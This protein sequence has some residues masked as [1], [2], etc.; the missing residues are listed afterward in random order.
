MPIRNRDQ[1]IFEATRVSTESQT[2]TRGQIFGYI[3]GDL[4]VL[5][6]PPKKTI[7]VMALFIIGCFALGLNVDSRNKTLG[8]SISGFS[9]FKY[10]NLG[11]L[12]LVMCT[13]VLTIGIIVRV[14]I[15]H[16]TRGVEVIFAQFKRIE[17][18][19]LWSDLTSVNVGRFLFRLQTK[20]IDIII[21]ERILLKLEAVLPSIHT[22]FLVVG[23]VW[24][25]I[26]ICS[27]LAIAVLSPSLSMFRPELLSCLSTNLY[28]NLAIHTVPFLGILF[29]KCTLPYRI[30][31]GGIFSNKTLLIC[32]GIYGAVPIILGLVFF[33]ETGELVYPFLSL[34]TL[35][36]T[37]LGALCVGFIWGAMK[38]IQRILRAYRFAPTSIWSHYQPFMREGFK[39]TWVEI[40]KEH[41][42]TTIL[43]RFLLLPLF[44]V[45]LGL[46]IFYFGNSLITVQK[47]QIYVRSICTE[48]DIYFGKIS[49]SAMGMSR[50]LS[51]ASAQNPLATQAA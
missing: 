5:G 45:S 35:K 41:S 3:N 47:V 33:L 31:E 30:D 46:A 8:V 42:K 12:N 14:A 18:G 27:F 51:S 13:A 17:D 6:A 37:I 15:R 34:I 29:D 50:R 10:G 38:L 48:T 16:I 23:L 7:F 28:T 11:Q 36:G 22:G 32:I 39:R 44:T 43:V 40:R 24:S 19:G 2:P 4:H 25:F 20:I 26:G 21:T 9:M 1:R 49:A